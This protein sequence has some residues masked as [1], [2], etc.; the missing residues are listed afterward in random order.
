MCFVEVIQCRGAI[1]VR[2]LF[3]RIHR[4]SEKEWIVWRKTKSWVVSTA[5]SQRCSGD[6]KKAT[7]RH[8]RQMKDEWIIN[9]FGNSFRAEMKAESWPP[10][11]GIPMTAETRMNISVLCYNSSSNASQFFTVPFSN[12]D[13]NSQIYHYHQTFQPTATVYFSSKR[14]YSLYAVE[15][16]GFDGPTPLPILFFFCSSVGTRVLF[17]KKRKQ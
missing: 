3:V 16:G 4:S 1:I 11:R 13:G 15:V 12:A 17:E 10:S 9:V 5:R 2:W 7:K 6:K 14:L 8:E